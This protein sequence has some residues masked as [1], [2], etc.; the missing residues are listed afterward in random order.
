MVCVEMLVINVT[1]KLHDQVDDIYAHD[2]AR[3]SFYRFNYTYHTCNVAV[4]DL[5]IYLKSFLFVNSF[6]CLFS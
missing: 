3:Y 6:F 1:Q 2:G 5:Q 4:D